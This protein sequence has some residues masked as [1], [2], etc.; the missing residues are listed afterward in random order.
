MRG[1]D[2]IIVDNF[3]D[4]INEIGNALI[5]NTISEDLINYHVSRILAWKLY[6]G[7]MI[8]EK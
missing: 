5:N 2:L 4:A 1:N 8:D 7:M 6:K 3:D